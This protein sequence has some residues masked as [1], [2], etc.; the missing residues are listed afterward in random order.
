MMP[1]YAETQDAAA[2]ILESTAI[3]QCAMRQDRDET[4]K[5]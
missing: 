5:S 4:E 1:F 2:R 3:P